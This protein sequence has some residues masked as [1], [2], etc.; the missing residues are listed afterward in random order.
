[1][2]CFRKHSCSFTRAS[3][4]CGNGRFP[5]I[6]NS[7]ASS[8]LATIVYL[9]EID[10]ALYKY[11]TTNMHCFLSFRIVRYVDDMYILIS[12]DKSIEFLYESYNEIRNE[13]SSILKSYGLAL[14]SK[15]CCLKKTTEI[16][17]E[18]KKSL[19]DEFFNGKKHNIED[20][21]REHYIAFCKICQ[22]N[23]CLTV[24]M[25]KNTINW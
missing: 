13:Y 11:I 14:N 5:L 3:L 16:N 4:Y 15:K 2:W 19:Y 7:I 18:L 17:Q 24:S 9:D 23:Y 10:A 6:E 21:L 20:L 12:S 1:M 25:L 8:Y 22:L